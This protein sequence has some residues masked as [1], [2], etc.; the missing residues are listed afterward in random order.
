MEPHRRDNV[1]TVIFG[2]IVDVCQIVQ[3]TLL[4]IPNSPFS[5]LPA[6][7]SVW[8]L[9]GKL[10][11]FDIWVQNCPVLKSGC[12]IV[13]LSKCLAPNIL[14]P[15]C[16][17]VQWSVHQIYF[18]DILCFHTSFSGNRKATGAWTWSSLSEVAEREVRL[19]GGVHQDQELLP[20]GDNV[21]Q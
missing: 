3:F 4:S 14:V 5:Y 19:H 15:N 9:S 20:R 8:L 21:Q 10:S 2:Y 11:C 13:L 7:L 1:V 6:K 16:L 12:K 18:S 17:G